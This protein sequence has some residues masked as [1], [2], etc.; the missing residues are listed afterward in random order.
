MQCIF[1]L[2]GAKDFGEK[3]KKPYG[4][5]EHSLTDNTSPQASNEIQLVRRCTDL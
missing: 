5:I 1:V 2:V 3:F 4:R